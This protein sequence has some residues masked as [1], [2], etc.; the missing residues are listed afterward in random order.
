[1]PDK[2]I[3]REAIAHIEI[4]NT[5][6]SKVMSWVVAVS[7]LVFIFAV[8]VIQYQLD[9]RDQKGGIFLNETSNDTQPGGSLFSNIKRKNILTL[10]KLD[11]LETS[12]EEGSFLR[13]I[14]LP[15][16]QSFL[17]NTLGQ[18]N[19]KVVVGREGWLFFRPGVDSLTGRPLLD[20][21]HLQMRFEG[22]ELWERPVQPDPLK[23]IVDFHNQLK[24][25][26]I[27]LI[28]VPIPVKP[29]IHG[30]KLSGNRFFKPPV[31]QDLEK[32]LR[33]LKKSDIAVFD[34]RLLLLQYG[35]EHGAAF[36]KT[37]THWLPGAMDV[38]AKQLAE[39]LKTDFPA[40][41]SSQLFNLQQQ[42]IEAE[43]DVAKMLTL[44]E[45]H[46]PVLQSV[47]V[48]QVVN[49]ENE[50]WQPDTESDILLLG[51]SFTNIY[52]T[53]GL[54]WGRNGGF[55]E[56]LS[57]HLQ[58]PV[59]LLSRNDSGAFV[60][61]EMLAL[62][63][64]RGRD[65]LQGKK[66]VIWEFAER[67]LTHGDWKLIDLTLGSPTESG[68][69]V[70]EAEQP[71][72]VQGVIGAVA[73]SPRP[74]SVPYR[75]NIITLHLVDLKGEKVDFAADQ[76]LVYGF[77]MRD[78]KLTDM[79]SL[80]PGDRVNIS[81]SAWEEV[82]GEYGSYRRSPLDDEMMELELPNWGTLY[83]EK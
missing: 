17:L 37:D 82:E 66:V 32:F 69:F 74:G 72:V 50:L 59:D 71:V 42:A 73:K 64:A 34:S 52:S 46:M 68:F 8:P 14:F 62:E 76:A 56:H 60:T 47:T 3:T 27:E 22:H 39:K 35:Q 1:M 43:G 61:R 77:G 63:L 26:G 30:E 45:N 36:L 12:L 55:A 28:L 41:E 20:A 81:L 13:S 44:P 29:S 19:E 31:N 67:E 9:N 2:K 18:G 4:G 23:A 70:S 11:L 38:V 78:N 40:S 53:V 49:N 51:D 24:G 58:R 79:A 83:H 6:I 16:L 7:F 15:P 80:R 48:D 65:R 25:R 57:Y 54:G 21:D 33:E 5:A 75:D 10:E